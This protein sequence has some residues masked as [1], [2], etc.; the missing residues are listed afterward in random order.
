MVE[1]QQHS[2]NLLHRI[3]NRTAVTVG[4]T[5]GSRIVGGS[6]IGFALFIAS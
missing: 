5:S 6:S 2:K 3:Y 1:E 4:N